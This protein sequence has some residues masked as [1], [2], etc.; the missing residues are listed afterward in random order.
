MKKLITLLGIIILNFNANS[1]TNFAP[2]GA[3]WHFSID[4]TAGYHYYNV[5]KDSVFQGENCR[6]IKAYNGADSLIDELFVL[7]SADIIFYWYSGEFRKAMDFTVDEGDSTFFDVKTYKYDT[8]EPY[9]LE[10][11][12]IIRFDGVISNINPD[13]INGE[14]VNSYEVEVINPSG[15]LGIEFFTYT[16]LLGINY[17]SDCELFPII[18]GF[19][20]IPEVPNPFLRCYKDTALEY[21]KSTWSKPCDYYSSL[22]VNN[23]SNSS[24]ISVY[25]NPVK[26]NLTVKS[27]NSPIES[28]SVYD[29]QGRLVLER[30]INASEAE[31]STDTFENGLYFFNLKT[32]SGTMMKKVVKN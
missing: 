30:E 1:Q 22:S 11:D 2:I 32:S 21:V 20:T 7:D 31:I 4:G 6:Y 15:Y 25:P 9:I 13:T 23:A 26:N 18:T 3:E 28:I 29:A 24:K 19:V 10:R 12:T 16:R 14:I 5:V 17:Y 8:T 27:Q